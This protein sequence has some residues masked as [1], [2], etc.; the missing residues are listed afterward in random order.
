MF[1]LRWFFR[2]SKKGRPSRP[3]VKRRGFVRRL[4]LRLE[5]LEDRTLLSADMW[6]NP[7]GGNW[8]VGSNWS[9]GQ[10]PGT[11]DT[12]VIN[13]TG[14]A[15]ITINSGDNIQVQGLTTGSNDTLSIAAG[16]LTVTSG[17]ST[18]SGALSMTFGSLTASG[19][20]VNLTANGSTDISG[21]NL[22]AE[23]GADLSLPQLTSYI[24]NSNY[25]TFQADGT[26]SVLD[27]SALTSL[28]LQN[29][30]VVNATNG[31]EVNLTGLT[32]LGSAPQVVYLTDTGNSTVLDSNLTTLDGVNVT[33]DGTDKSVANSWTTFTNGYLYVTGGSYSLAG[34]TDVDSSN[35]FV[36]NGGS[37]ALPG[38]IRFDADNGGN[39]TFQAD[40]A[41]S[42]LDVSKLTNLTQTESAW[43]V[44]ATNGGEVNLTG[45]TNLGSN[46]DLFLTDTG[47][48]TLLLN[49]NLTTLDG[50]N[51]TLDGT[52]KSVANSWTTF[53]NGYL[54]VTGG[55]YS[56]A[57]LTDVDGSNLFVSNGGS[58]ALPGLTSYASTFTTFQ[59]DGTGSVLDVSALTSLTQQSK[60]IVNAFNGGEV[61]LSGM[62]SLDGPQGISLTAD[63][64][65]STID[66]SALTSLT[67][68]N[69]SITLSNGGEVK[70]TGLTSLGSDSPP[71]AFLTITDTGNSTLLLNSNLT[72]LDGVNVTLDGTDNSVANSW[73]T[74]TNAS[75]S[76]TGGTVTLP[77]LIDFAN[78]NLYL[79]GGAA[80][81]FPVL[82][83]GNLRLTNG[84]SVT[85]QGTEISLPADGTSGATINVPSSQ[86]LTVTLQ[87]SGTLTNTTINV[88]AGTTV[89]LAGGTYLGTTTF[90][91]GQGASV[92]LT[93]GQT[94]T[95]GG[96]LTGSGAGSVVFSS[97]TLYPASGGGV[98][99]NFPG[100][101]FQWTGGAI[102]ASVG[103]VTNQGTINLGGSNDK[104]I[105]ADGTLKNYGTIIQTGSGNFDLHSDNVSPT[106]L[107]NEAGGVYLFESDSG[108]NNAGLGDNV[109]INAGTIR[110]TA[111]TGTSTLYVPSQ[112]YISS[113]GTIEADSGTLFLDANSISQVAGNTLTAG[114]WNAMNGAS[115]Q[116]PSGTNITSNAA[117]VS[118]GGSGANITALAGLTSNSGNFSVTGGA[119]FTTAGDSS[120]SDSLTVGAGSTFTVAGNYTQ[121][122]AG[123]LN[124]QIGGTP[125]SG[126]FG[127]VAVQDAANLAGNFNLSLV[128]GF[129][130]GSGQSY[131]VM[132]FAS[133]SGA[134]TTFTGLSPYFTEQSN[135]TSLDLTT[136]SANAV[137][138]GVTSVTAPTTATTGQPIAVNWT[139]S[140]PGGNAASGSW[141]DSVYLSATLAITS[142]SI[143]LG[144]VTHSGGLAAGGSYNGSLTAAVPA[145]PPGHY[146]VLVQADSLYQVP[147]SNRTNNTL[148]ASTGQLAVSVPALTLGTPASATFAAADQD[149]FYQVTVPAGGSLQ[150]ALTSAASSGALAL[151]VS[152]GTLPTPYSYQEAANL[153]GQPNQSL[154]VPVSAAGTYYI[155][156]HSVS[157]AAATAGYTLTVTQTSA[158][159]VSGI[160][161]YSGGNASNV[162]IEIDGA[163]FTPQTTASLTLGKTTINA[164]AID[165]VSGSQL[166]A[167]FNLGLSE[168][169]V[170]NYT[171]SVQQGAESAT[172]PT[173]FQVVLPQAT[174][175]QANSEYGL[176]ITL[177]LPQFVR[178]GRTGTIVLTYT[179]VSN[180]D[181]D[182]PLLSI[183]ST[184]PN[185]YFSTPDD[186]NH[187][188]Q[189]AQVLA[190]AP[191]GPAGILRPAR[192]ARSP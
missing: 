168:A 17:N 23:G 75:L 189:M 51:V 27:V 175:A 119:D 182:A 164:S 128:N 103:D 92:D 60:W 96:T 49:S 9:S 7:N 122:A 130:P 104:Q 134:F 143:L 151:Y 116:F 160:S 78:S 64:G 127:Q 169:T 112:G 66:L 118:L 133:A 141:Q 167:T 80:L 90:N 48:S 15:T 71:L 142:S 29:P 86:E 120:N 20:G 150:L 53:T 4:P 63:G 19:S 171:L 105:Y 81:N 25:D 108:I 152:Q 33:L 153:A 165:F 191:N 137:D 10:A 121:T 84:T 177:G 123:A 58:L 102:E 147:D 22:T 79:S 62:T 46:G 35:L 34:L 113:T 52:D 67:G 69:S 129:T 138:L 41:G 87:N 54:Y 188:V 26:G 154:N 28:T 57:G 50:V 135:S 161:P 184:N 36:S 145:L 157:G 155:L 170:G 45:L 6:I 162:T 11:G 24:S 131:P 156:V 101:M 44:E 56:L 106:T 47:N 174:G 110:K 39:S 68:L 158:L 159:S 109:I 94:T 117:N 111:G 91:L 13:T 125:A 180:M 98:T 37:L 144:S 40:G 149:Q 31:G 85:V 21:A 181:L 70:L 77:N 14:A 148:A 72:T 179:N 190:V 42:V 186:P 146:Y 32:N 59:A 176:Y 166:F 124:V 178:S 173:K 183:A 30:W 43:S 114:T 65:G 136:G 192:A 93:G 132:T 95:Y 61:K 126:Q 185:V 76:V 83:Q 100:S 187:F 38:L 3:V 88:G 140:D 139:V 89:V 172:A 97:G 12:A 115:L 2:R 74:F 99:L 82:T 16:S 73:T 8:D 107:D 1:F 163:N 55:S 18:L 5:R